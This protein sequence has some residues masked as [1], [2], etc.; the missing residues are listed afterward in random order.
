[1]PIVRPG[2]ASQCLFFLVRSS[3]SGSG[4]ENSGSGLEY[5]IHLV[6]R[7]GACSSELLCRFRGK[8]ELVIKASGVEGAEF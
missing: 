3:V 8:I 4:L 2:E 6:C 5:S 1:M 7:F